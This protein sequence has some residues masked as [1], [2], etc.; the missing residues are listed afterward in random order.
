M[1]R[2]IIILLIFAALWG[3]DR[4]YDGEDTEDTTTYSSP[5]SQ[6]IVPEAE[7]ESF[8]RE[9]DMQIEANQAKLRELRN[10][11]SAKYTAA[12]AELEEKNEALRREL[13]QFSYET[14]ER[15]LAFRDG[16]SRNLQGLDDGI[17]GVYTKNGR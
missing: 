7:W 10:T 14:E 1:Y 5:Q 8:K 6:V 15:W 11:V 13:R 4:N 12:V 16:F 3:C 17:D 2:S 9:T